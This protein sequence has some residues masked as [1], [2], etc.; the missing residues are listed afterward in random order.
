MMQPRREL[1][2][3]GYVKSIMT[4][5]RNITFLSV[6]SRLQRTF[7]GSGGFKGLILSMF[8]VIEEV[9]N[10]RAIQLASVSGVRLDTD[11]GSYHD[12]LRVPA[13]HPFLLLSQGILWL[14]V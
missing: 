8:G 7:D 6:T 9:K 13:I 3:A 12:R 4:D 10:N 2:I 14:M 5:E 1:G 11:L